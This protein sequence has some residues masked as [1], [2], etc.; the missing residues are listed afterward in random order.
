MSKL[1][2]FTALGENPVPQQPRRTPMIATYRPTSG[3]EEAPSQDMAQ[4]GAQLEQASHAAL[5][6]KVA[7]DSMR[8]DDAFNQLRQKQMDMTFG[9]DGFANLKGGDAVNRPL[10]KDYGAAFDTTAAQL[11]NGLGNDLQKQLFQKRAQSAGL[12]LREDIGRHVMHEQNVYAETTFTATLDSS[13]KLAGARWDK[14]DAEATSMLS[15]ANAVDARARWLGLQGET[16]QNWVDAQMATASSKVYSEMVKAALA[17]D[18]VKGPFAAEALLK[19]HG[20]Q[21]DATSQVVLTHEVYNAL[22]PVQARADAQDAV[23]DIL[24][25]VGENVAVGGQRVL[26]QI[27]AS[28]ATP[29]P[30][31]YRFKTPAGNMVE[32]IAP[33]EQEAHRRMAIGTGMLAAAKAE[34]PTKIDTMALIGEAI[35]RAE[36]RAEQTHPGDLL[37]HDMVVAQ[38]KSQ[39]STI[40]QI[41][42]GV[43]K[44]NY[45]TL[46]KAL[47]P[48]VLTSPGGT[49]NAGGQQPLTPPPTTQEQ[50]FSN[51]A[52]RAAFDALDP[53]QQSGVLTHL[54][55]NAN[56]ALGHPMKENADIVADAAN[57]VFL[58]SG[59]PNKITNYGQIIPLLNHGVGQSGAAFLFGLIDKSQS[60]DGVKLAS[61]ANRAFQS[62]RST[63][64]HSMAG[65]I[66]PE[67][68]ADAANQYYLWVQTQIDTYKEQGKDTRLLF[69][70]TING[71]P[72]SE[73]VLDHGKVMSFM[74]QSPK[75]A[76]DGAAGASKA[77]PVQLTKGQE[78]TEFAALPAGAR[79]RVE[80]DPPGKFRTKPGTP[81]PSATRTGDW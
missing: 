46:I 72:N 68:A 13:A 8:A 56:A 61:Q 17:S 2:D 67:V 3:F 62:A 26:D 27:A 77:P 80:T 30:T 75:Q 70:P 20:K 55:H 22:R 32:G 43:Q 33:S 57:R 24:P 60:V 42:Q 71:K 79:Y 44:Q 45:A 39:F 48:G 6:A 5:E 16:R 15:V 21:M 9:K 52:N 65:Q 58:P 28:D 19:L 18:P 47:M 66:Q 59:D 63:L 73:W 41:E 49:M 78:E 51:P 40:A 53:L 34:S 35:G 11:G 37:Y 74:G 1:P 36:Q 54:A 76:V 31:S 10:L 7:V 81:N 64:S 69:M 12:Q 4:S 25:K 29:S 50:L 38:V 14:P 23:K